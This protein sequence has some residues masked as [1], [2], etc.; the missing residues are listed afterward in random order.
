MKTEYLTFPNQP[1]AAASYWFARIHSG[2]LTRAEHEAFQHWRQASPNNEKEYQAL[3]EIWQ[4]TSMLSN[5]DLQA[6]MTEPHPFKKTSPSDSKRRFLLGTSALCAVAAVSTALLYAK[7]SEQ[8]EQELHYLTTRGEQRQADLPDG[9]SILLN[10]D[11]E[12]RIRYYATRREVELLTGE[13]LF[14]VT[15][16]SARPFLVHAGTV[17]V[18]VTGTVFSVRH[19]SQ[20]TAVAVESGSVHLQSGPWW[21]RQQA[22]LAS[23]MLARFSPGAPFNVQAASVTALT[24]WQHGR[25][26]FQGQALE[27]VVQEMNRYLTHPLHLQD[28]ALKR[29]PIS[30]VFSIEDADGFLQSLQKQVAITL[31]P[32]ADGGTNLGLQR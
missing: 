12:V 1:R 25:L 11:T 31:S 21:N 6:L 4:A 27:Q 32:R 17:D 28:K 22:D 2:N 3:S 24:A 10:V 18:R 5:T 15:K 19:E 29:I 7:D 30:G 16:N 9:S 26:V 13:A 14:T 20:H 23:G 8:P